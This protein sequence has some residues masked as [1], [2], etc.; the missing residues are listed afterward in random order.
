VDDYLER[1]VNGR[2]Q[3]L[4]MPPFLSVAL[5]EDA[6]WNI[7]QAGVRVALERA[8]AVRAARD[9][10]G[11]GESQPPAVTP[12]PGPAPVPERTQ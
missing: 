8:R 12:A 7:D 4:P 9:S 5:R 10:A 2:A 3:F 11:L 6:A 1:V